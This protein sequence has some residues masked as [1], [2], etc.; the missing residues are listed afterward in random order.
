MRTIPPSGYIQAA[1]DRA[2]DRF[3]HICPSRYLTFPPDG[4]TLKLIF[5]SLPLSVLVA[6][7]AA[8]SMLRFMCLTSLSIGFVKRFCKSRRS[9][10]SEICICLRIC[11]RKLR[12]DT[13][14]RLM[15][16]CKI[17][18]FSP[19]PRVKREFVRHIFPSLV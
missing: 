1:A 8:F 6:P 10:S 7:R 12:Y 2:E 11:P 19:W 13:L 3:F 9:Y 18:F 5:C 4:D 16:I 17:R 14:S 15:Q